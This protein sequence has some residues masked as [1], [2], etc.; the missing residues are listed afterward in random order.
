[1]LV[2]HHPKSFSHWTEMS[3]LG[4]FGLLKIAVLHNVFCAWLIWPKTKSGVLSF[5]SCLV[6]LSEW[7]RLSLGTWTIN[8]IALPPQVYSHLFFIW[9]GKVWSGE[10]SVASSR[11]QRKLLLWRCADGGLLS[12]HRPSCLTTSL[13]VLPKRGGL[14]SDTGEQANVRWQGWL[15]AQGHD[16]LCLRED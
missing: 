12:K 1:M 3:L 9:F 2:S 6:T 13:Q 10:E 16:C 4:K 11:A 8:T 15:R 5:Y 14:T 7:W